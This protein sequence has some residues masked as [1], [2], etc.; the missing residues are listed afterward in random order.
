MNAGVV[1]PGAHGLAHGGPARAP[2]GLHGEPGAPGGQVVGPEDGAGWLGL[3]RGFDAQAEGG[4][5]G[6]EFGLLGL[7]IAGGAGELARGPEAGQLGE[8]FR[9]PCSP[10]LA[11]MAFW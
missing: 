1:Q 7:G 8:F 9:R 11:K 3:G 6:V 10:S 2:L 5:G 4:G